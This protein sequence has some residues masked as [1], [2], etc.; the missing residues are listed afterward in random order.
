M[1]DA[2]KLMQDLCADSLTSYIIRC[3]DGMKECPND[4]PA[5]AEA[6]QHYV[7][8][9]TPAFDNLWELEGDI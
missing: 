8:N 3:G 4:R 6:D 1:P 5:H 7:T 2:C 9:Q